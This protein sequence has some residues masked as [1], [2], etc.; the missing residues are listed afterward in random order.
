MIKDMRAFGIIERREKK[1]RLERSLKRT[2][3]KITTILECNLKVGSWFLTL[4]FKDDIRDYDAANKLWLKYIRLY[5][6]DISYIL[7]K[8]LQNESRDGVIHYHLIIFNDL[9]TVIHW[10]YGWYYPKK[11]KDLNYSRISNYFASYLS[12]ESKNQL[13]NSGKKIFSYSKNIKRPI[14]LD[15][16]VFEYTVEKKM[17]VDFKNITLD[18]YNTIKEKITLVDIAE[19]WFGREKVKICK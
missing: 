19:L 4:T 18:E 5:L 13:V 17:N 10:P 9:N 12:D 3:Q 8:E 7:I 6:N 14:L 11:I 2:K 16:Y 1:E 15:D